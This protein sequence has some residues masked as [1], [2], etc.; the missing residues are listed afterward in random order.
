MSAFEKQD[1]RSAILDAAERRARTGGYNG[2][3]FRDLA[4]DVGIKSA[5][6]H[7]HFPTKEDLGAAITERYTSR[8]IESLG[9]P[10]GLSGAEAVDRVAGLFVHANEVD[11]LMCLC[12]L[13]GAEAGGLP[14]PTVLE[15]KVYFDALTNWLCEAL[16]GPDRTIRAEMIVATLEGALIISRARGDKEQLHRLHRQLRRSFA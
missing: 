9:D 1:K 6:V 12:G 16:K 15:V 4:E 7:Y 13:F 11:D 2:F 5:S 10:A 8:A 14:Q 3:S